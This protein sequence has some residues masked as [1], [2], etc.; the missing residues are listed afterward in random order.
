MAY[1]HFSLICVIIILFG[2]SNASE[3]DASIP[4]TAAHQKLIQLCKNDYNL[5]IVTTAHDNTLWIYLPLDQSFLSITASKDG[6]SKSPDFEEKHQIHY[7]DGEFVNDAFQIHYDIRLKKLYTDNKGIDTK[8][9]EEY[10]TKQRFLLSAITRAYSEIEKEPNSNRYVE[11]IAGD[12]DFVGK[13]KNA[14]HKKLVHSYVKTSAVPDFFVIV[15]ADIEK[16][17]ES[18]MYLYLQDLRRSTHDQGFS[19]E[20]VK[21]AVVMQPVGHEIIIGDKTGSHLETYDL[22]WVEFLTKQMVYRIT[23]KYTFSSLPPLPDT[24]QQLIDIAAETIQA[25][26]FDEF[27]SLNLVDL[28]T[29]TTDTF[30]KADLKAI[31]IT[32]P[33]PPGKLH[34]I[35]LE[36]GPPE[37]E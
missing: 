10:S 35:K 15:I 31:E 18:R 29:N 34:K 32:P 1:K 17:I 13:K 19:E 4:T 7:L 3:Q 8:Y 11:K 16:G 28:E 21:R 36:I 6:P 12:V 37:E 5:D 26:D 25:Y 24:K 9:S 30:S 23:L 33:R 2:C 20:Y 22:S 14:T 27:H